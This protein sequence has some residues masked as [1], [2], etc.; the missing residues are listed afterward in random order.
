[1]NTP[2]ERLKAARE[3]A[4]ISTRDLDRIAGLKQGVCWSVENSNSGNYE[5]RTLNALATT[6]GLSLDFVV[7]GV[8]RLPSARKVKAAVAIARAAREAA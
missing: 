4:A 3:A 2:G 8:G 1:M 7:R 6:L 5:V